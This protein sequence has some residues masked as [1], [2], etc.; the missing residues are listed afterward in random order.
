MSGSAFA[1]APPAPPEPTAEEL[2]KPSSTPLNLDL[3]EPSSPESLP[4]AMEED[5]ETEPPAPP[6]APPAPPPPATKKPGFRKTDGLPG[7]F[8]GE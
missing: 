1:S 5:T 3:F 6:P 7:L 2:A 8:G 4:L